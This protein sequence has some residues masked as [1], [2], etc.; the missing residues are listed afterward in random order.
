MRFV[1]YHPHQSHSLGDAAKQ[2]AQIASIKEMEAKLPRLKTSKAPPS[3][4]QEKAAYDFITN[5]LEQSS[6]GRFSSLPN[7]K[8]LGAKIKT[9][10]QARQILAIDKKYIVAAARVIYN[11]SLLDK[12]L[13]NIVEANVDLMMANARSVKSLEEQLPSDDA[14][15]M[16]ELL[17]A[18]VAL[19]TLQTLD[20]L[21]FTKKMVTQSREESTIESIIDAFG[22]ALAKV[23]KTAINKVIIPIIEQVPKVGFALAP[24]L[25]PV[26]LAFGGFWLAKN[27][28]AKN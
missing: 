20:N 22:D 15:P 5:E 4:A 8:R 19:T 14:A 24:L 11:Y 21:N 2:D 13:T 26:G 6:T 12:I 10:G 27:I 17:S 18:K 16:P 28:L 7:A 3:P 25:V 1:G 9:A 23:L